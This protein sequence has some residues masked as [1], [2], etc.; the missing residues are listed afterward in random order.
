MKGT[1]PWLRAALA[2]VACALC[3]VCAG[4]AEGEL[5]RF[6]VIG[7]FGSS[8]EGVK[9]GDDLRRAERLVAEMVKGW[10]P[11]FVITL[12]DNN[13]E[14]GAA[15]TI[16]EN[17]GQYYCDFIY[18]PGAPAGQVCAGRAA[19][20]RQNRFFPTIGNHDCYAPGAAPHLAY[21]SGLPG[22]RRYYD[23]AQGPVQLFA[24]N[25]ESREACAKQEE[26]EGKEA[27]EREAQGKAPKGP[28]CG[29]VSCNCEPDG[30]DQNS[31]QARWLRDALK[32]SKSEWKLAFFH[33]PPY[34][35]REKT[36]AEWMRWPFEAWGASGV[37]SGHRHVYERIVRRDSPDFPYF[38]NGVGGTE[39]S[40]CKRDEIPANLPPDEFDAIHVEDKH[41]AML[42]EATE[43]QLTI[44]F[45][46]VNDEG[47]PKLRDTCRLTKTGSGQSLKCEQSSK[48]N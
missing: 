7:D 45:Y 9:G 12:G 13:Y 18:N 36:T 22:N 14:C 31:T 33:R 5:V 6:A 47:E 32:A 2:F 37:L 19:R 20:D 48:S 10:D 27:E 38:V 25:S 1:R 29:G 8:S 17:I 15:E 46:S 44:Q 16:V 40:G 23:I 35:C 41:G 34:S 26:E 28:P 11:A 21:F 24:L 3:G 43:R 4:D 42:V 30:A 39:L